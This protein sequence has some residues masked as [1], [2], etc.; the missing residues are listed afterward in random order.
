[1]NSFWA[2]M[3][4]VLIAAPSLYVAHRIGKRIQER[5][6]AKRKAFLDEARPRYDAFMKDQPKYR[7]MSGVSVTGRTT[8]GVEQFHGWPPEYADNNFPYTPTGHWEPIKYG[9][10]TEKMALAILKDFL[11]PS[12]NQAKPFTPHAYYDHEGKKHEHRAD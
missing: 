6:A 3:I 11:K 7:T 2:I 1:M 4:T 9:L 12:S 5:E 10:A 8:W